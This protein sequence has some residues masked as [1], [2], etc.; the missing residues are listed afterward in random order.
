MPGMGGNRFR[1]F[2][3]RVPKRECDDIND[4]IDYKNLPLLFK[5]LTPQGKLQSRKRTKYCAQCQRELARAVKHA[6]FIG[7]LP[8][9]I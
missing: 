7:L 2:I 3:A 6:R 4:P 9:V 5:Y 8:Y 1:K